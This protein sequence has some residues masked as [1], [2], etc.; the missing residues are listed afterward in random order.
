VLTPPSRPATRGAPALALRAAG[1]LWP[2][3]I[4]LMSF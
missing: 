1:G 3:R 4:G 2:W